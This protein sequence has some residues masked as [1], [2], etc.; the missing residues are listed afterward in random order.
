MHVPS[1]STSAACELYRVSSPMMLLPAA[2]PRPSQRSAK[3]GKA[4]EG[5]WPQGMRRARAREDLGLGLFARTGWGAARGGCADAAWD[6]VGGR[7]A[8]VKPGRKRGGRRGQLVADALPQQAELLVERLVALRPIWD[9]EEGEE[10]R[11]ELGCTSNAWL[12][13]EGRGRD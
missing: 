8:H 3:L 7:R 12:G 2:W 9:R 1:S 6:R 5:A 11:G 10:E 4:S 13:G